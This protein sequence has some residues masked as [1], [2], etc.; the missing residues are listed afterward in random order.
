MKNDKTHAL[1]AVLP[2]IDFR[3]QKQMAV[4]IKFM[5]LKKLL[6]HYDTVAQAKNA[7][8]NWRVSFL[9]AAMPHMNHENQ[10]N[11]GQMLQA[12]E[13]QEMMTKLQEVPK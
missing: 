5:E 8:E 3:Y 4:A 11:L 2:H 1:L 7:G 6:S 12:L 9:K 13:M 10:K